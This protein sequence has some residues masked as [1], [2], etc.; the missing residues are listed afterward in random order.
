M[1]LF[2][3][4]STIKTFN[5]W[6]IFKKHFFLFGRLFDEPFLVHSMYIYIVSTLNEN[7][8][9]KEIRKLLAYLSSCAA[10][11]QP[12]NT[13]NLHLKGPFTNYDYKRRGVVSPK[14][15]IFCQYS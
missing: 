4:N 14:I 7:R 1:F 8:I 9:N 5:N 13:N 15:S 6:F 11:A 2:T 3:N 12:K 10:D